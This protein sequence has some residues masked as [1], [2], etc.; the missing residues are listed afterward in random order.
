MNAEMRSNILAHVPVQEL[1]VWRTSIEKIGEI[2]VIH[3]P[4]MGLV[5]MKAQE[6]AENVQFYVGE[7][8]ITDCTVSVD[9][10]LG[11]A[12]R[13]G[14]E[15]E[16]VYVLAVV[17]AISCKQDAK[18]TGWL[19]EFDSWLLEKEAEQRQDRLFAH[20]LTKRTLVD[21]DVMDTD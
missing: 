8:L 18:W 12:A 17:D 3:E 9:G 19:T 20:K 21:F 14:N 7:V 15:P 6:S 2:E 5:M 4:A 11:Y 13:M 10:D 1:A 16:A